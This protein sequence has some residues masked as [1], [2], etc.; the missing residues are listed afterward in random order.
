MA[1]DKRA[2]FS[3][4]ESL[5]IPNQLGALSVVNEGTIISLANRLNLSAVNLLVPQVEV[6]CEGSCL[7][8]NFSLL[9]DKLYKSDLYDMLGWYQV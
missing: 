5:C 4:T 9:Q 1:S 6:L 7:E 2:I 8:D 3:I